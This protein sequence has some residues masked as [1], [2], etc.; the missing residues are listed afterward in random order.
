MCKI[1]RHQNLTR[2][3]TWHHFCRWISQL[4]L[5]VRFR[6]TSRCLVV[7]WIFFFY[8]FL[9]SCRATDVATGR[10]RH[11][12]KDI[13]RRKK[14]C[15][16]VPPPHYR[17]GR[18]HVFPNL[19]SLELPAAALGGIGVR[20]NYHLFNIIDN[21]EFQNVIILL[22]QED[23]EDINRLVLKLPKN[24]DVKKST[25]GKAT[26]FKKRGSLELQKS[27][28]KFG[29]GTTEGRNG[30]TEPSRR[31][32]VVQIFLHHT[33]FSLLRAIFSRSSLI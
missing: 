28:E 23:K 26:E 14:L 27:Y 12:P 9:S 11:D 13:A 15:I 17:R 21:L 29:G 25:I 10:A 22:H 32:P 5:S 18:P 33:I 8:P 3:K 30:G 6:R 19:T 20:K 2:V 7:L 16:R 1:R 31:S 24:H 4:D